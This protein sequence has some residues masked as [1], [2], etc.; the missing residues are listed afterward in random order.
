M[1]KEQREYLISRARH[2]L[3]VCNIDGRVTVPSGF[4]EEIIDI[5]DKYG[6]IVD[7]AETLFP[8]ERRFAAMQPTMKHIN[9][10]SALRKLEE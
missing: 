3:A 6:D 7:A 8:K 4:L 9:V 5:L 2:G 1:H 10:C